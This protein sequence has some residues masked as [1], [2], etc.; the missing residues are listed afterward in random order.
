MTI[1]DLVS[2]FLAR[3]SDSAEAGNSVVVVPSLFFVKTCHDALSTKNRDKVLTNS[4]GP[5][6]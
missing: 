2:K 3:E 1:A 4:L 6:L 5:T